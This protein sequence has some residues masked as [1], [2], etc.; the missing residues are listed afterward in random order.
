MIR[1]AQ[2]ILSNGQA[3]TTTADS[4]NIVDLGDTRRGQGE[5]LFLDCHVRAAFNAGTSIKADLQ[6]SADG[7]TFASTGL[8]SAVVSTANAKAGVT[9]IKCGI[10]VAVRRYVKIVYTVVGT[11]DAGSV[12]AVITPGLVG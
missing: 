2:L 3:I 8:T 1:D 10:P 6:D 12:D 11:M 5:P 4:T 7:T 9:L